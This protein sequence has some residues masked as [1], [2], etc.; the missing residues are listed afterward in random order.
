MVRNALASGPVAVIVCD[1]AHDFVEAIRVVAGD[2]CEY[3]RMTA[4]GYFWV[5]EK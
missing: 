4:K 1:G 2:G 5:V 3:V